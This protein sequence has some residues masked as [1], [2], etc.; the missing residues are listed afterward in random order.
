MPSVVNWQSTFASRGSVLTTELNSLANN[1]LCAVGA[2][3]SNVNDVNL[4]QYGM[5]ELKVTFASAPT[6]GGYVNVYEVVSPDGTTYGDATTVAGDAGAMRFV[7]SIG[8]RAVTTAQ[9][10]H[11]MLAML[12]PAKAKYVLENKT[13]QAFPASGSTLALYTTNDEGQ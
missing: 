6:S 2:N 5:F 8:V 1:A 12:R 13:G 9:V 3:P 7:G 10:L 4:D 11:S